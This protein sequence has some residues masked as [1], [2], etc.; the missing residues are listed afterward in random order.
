MEGILE[1]FDTASAGIFSA[2][3]WKK[4]FFVLHQQVLLITDLTERTKVIGKMHM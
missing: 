3:N 4:Y 1:R 2:G